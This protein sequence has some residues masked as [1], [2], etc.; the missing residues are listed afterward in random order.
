M[1]GE[2][3]SYEFE[4]Q[5]FHESASERKFLVD[6]TNVEQHIGT[7]CNALDAAPMR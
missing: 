7:V 1:G 2:E 6:D 5:A 4:Q 3:Y